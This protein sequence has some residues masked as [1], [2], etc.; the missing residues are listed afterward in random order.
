EVLDARPGELRADEQRKQAA[1]EEE[2]DRRHEIL[3]ADHLVVGVDP[4][5]VLPALRAVTRVILRLRRGADAVAR[6]VVEGADAGKKADRRRDQCGDEHEW[7]RG[8]DRVP[9]ASP[10]D[11]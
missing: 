7:L 4:E 10:A 9:M 6:P 5:V 3:D 1:G 8:D 11:Y 2:E